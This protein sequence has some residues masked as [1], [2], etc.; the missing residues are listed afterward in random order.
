M[1]DEKWGPDKE[2]EG[3]VVAVVEEGKPKEV[4]EIDNLKKAL[5]EAKNSTPTLTEALTLLKDKWI[6]AYTSFSYLFPLLS[7]GSLQLASGGVM[8]LYTSLSIS[9]LQKDLFMPFFMHLEYHPDNDFFSPINAAWTANPCDMGMN[10]IFATPKLG[11]DKVKQCVDAKL[12]GEY[13]PKTVAKIVK[14]V[15][16]IQKA[17]EKKASRT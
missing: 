13:P 10:F 14:K 17:K 7:R 3:G 11:E 15:L 4:T 5:L 12:N 9:I 8:A 1:D 16:K 6:L 2:E